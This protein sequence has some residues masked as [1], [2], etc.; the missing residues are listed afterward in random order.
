M[1]RMLALDSEGGKE[2]AEIA[3]RYRTHG[4]WVMLLQT[5]EDFC[6]RKHQRIL[7]ISGGTKTASEH[8]FL[9]RML[10]ESGIVCHN[11]RFLFRRKPILVAGQQLRFQLGI[12]LGMVD[13]RAIYFVLQLHTRKRRLPVGSVSSSFWLEVAINEAIRGSEAKFF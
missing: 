10:V 4:G 7:A 5:L 12:Q 1:L 13:W 2:L 3:G 6:G 8:I 11:L 9:Y